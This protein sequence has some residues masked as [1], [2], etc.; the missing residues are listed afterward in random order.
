L[1]LILLNFFCCNLFLIDRFQWF[2]FLIIIALF[3]FFFVA[4]IEVN[5]TRICLGCSCCSLSWRIY[6]G[7]CHYWRNLLGLGLVHWIQHKLDVLTLQETLHAIK[8]VIVKKII[9]GRVILYRFLVQRSQ[10][11]NSWKWEIVDKGTLIRINVI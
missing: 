7:T 5:L 9:E 6:G 3:L 2:F 1:I 11:L 8:E 4:E 10:S